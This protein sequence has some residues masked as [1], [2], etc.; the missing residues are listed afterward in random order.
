MHAVKGVGCVRFQLESGGSLEVDE[1]MFV[2]ELRVNLLSV[3]ALEDKGYA[4][5][6]EDGQV[7]IRSEGATLD[8][9]VRLGIRRV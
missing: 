6:F 8:A 7:L 4:V 1:V 3:S 5:M 9:T 2:P